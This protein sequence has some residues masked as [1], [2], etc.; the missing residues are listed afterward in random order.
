[1][2]AMWA[3]RLPLAA[4]HA[5]AASWTVV[6]FVGLGISVPS[7]PGYVGVFHA[8]AVLALAMFGVPTAPAV[9]YAIVLHACGFIP[10]TLFGWVLLLREHVTLGQA[11][12]APAAVSPEP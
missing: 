5:A 9:G 6:A 8:A 1:L 2:T 7:A 4:F 12:R 10:I 3:A 11:A